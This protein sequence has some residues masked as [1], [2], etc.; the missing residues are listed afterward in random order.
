VLLPIAVKSVSGEFVRDGG[1]RPLAA[2]DTKSSLAS[3]FTP[4]VSAPSPSSLPL[5]TGL[6]APVRQLSGSSDSSEP[7]SASG[8]LIAPSLVTPQFTFG[9][10]LPSSVSTIPGQ[11]VL[12]PTLSRSSSS[13]SVA[14]SGTAAAPKKSTLNAN[15]KVPLLFSIPHLFALLD[16]LVHEPIFLCVEAFHWREKQERNT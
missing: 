15:A 4:A 7:P 1:A 5:P 6:G 14:S 3:P 12:S 16:L 13:A 11:A 9:A 2:H 10:Q 8:P